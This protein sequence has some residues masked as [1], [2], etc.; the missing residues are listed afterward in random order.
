MPS[1]LFETFPQLQQTV[2]LKK[3]NLGE[4]SNLFEIIYKC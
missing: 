2:K 4:G 3:K 1:F